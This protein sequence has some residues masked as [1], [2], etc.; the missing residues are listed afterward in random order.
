MLQPLKMTSGARSLR[1]VNASRK[2]QGL[3]RLVTG[4]TSSHSQSPRVNYGRPTEI[5]ARPGWNDRFNGSVPT[6]KHVVRRL[7]P[8]E[9][10]DTSGGRAYG[11]RRQAPVNSIEHE[12]RKIQSVLNERI[13]IQQQR[14]A[15]TALRERAQERNRQMERMLSRRR[16]PSTPPS[17]KQAERSM[18]NF[19]MA[20]PPRQS[21]A[22]GGAPEAKLQQLEAE[23]LRR[24]EAER[25]VSRDDVALRQMVRKSMLEHMTSNYLASTRPW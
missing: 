25:H 5:N 21:R 20:S 16:T 11:V 4:C 22:L 18:T 3:K 12:D 23:V 15:I 19:D 17:L 2:T 24:Y 1:Q 13:I 9:P 10:A 7:L 8:T 14:D 6:K